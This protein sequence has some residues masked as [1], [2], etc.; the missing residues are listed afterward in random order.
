M[1]DTI[2]MQKNYRNIL[3]IRQSA[4]GDVANVLPLLQ[5]IRLRYADARIT[6][7]TSRLTAA[8][9]RDDPCVDE[10][11]EFNRTRQPFKL[12]PM[13]LQLRRQQFDL[14]VDFQ[15][16][17]HSRWLTLATAAGTRLGYGGAPFL[18]QSLRLDIRNY[19]VCDIFRQMLAPLALND[20]PVQARFPHLPECKAAAN[21][22]LSAHAVLPGAY[23]V[24]NPGHS[25]A[26]GTKR[27]PIEH[28]I[29]L[30]CRL[31]EKGLSIVVT[32]ASSDAALAEQIRSGIGEGCISL[33]GKT[34]LNAL[35]GVMSLARAV[36]S[37]DSGPMHIAAMAGARVVAL[38]GPTNP[39][40]SAP[41]GTGHKVLHHELSCSYCFKKRCPYQHECLNQMLPDEV[42]NAV[43]GIADL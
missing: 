6:F 24:F 29:A 5:L 12:L 9:L 42:F 1:I 18:T 33:A 2:T 16:S 28:W 43:Q 14:V 25:P 31:I 17:S 8:L 20:M 38:F 23:V 4:L 21:L 37:T 19:Q 11:I 30:G 39:I 10:V 13:C 32:G 22:L 26:W 15:S 3:L 27:W 35:A 41:F 40:T 7:L 34:D 36:V